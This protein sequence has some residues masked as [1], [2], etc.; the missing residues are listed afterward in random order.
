MRDYGA[1][2]AGSA[3]RAAFEDSNVL[4]YAAEVRLAAPHDE[5]LSTEGLGAAGDGLLETTGGYGQSQLRCYGPAGGLVA[6]PVS[7]PADVYAEGACCVDGS[8]W[9]LTWRDGVALRWDLATLTL[10]GRL[11]YDR[12]GWGLCHDG[13]AVYCTDGSSEVVIRDPA[14]LAPAGSIRVR[15]AGGDEIDGLKAIA[16][17]GDQLWVGK[18]RSHWLMR[19]DRRTGLITGAVNLRDAFSQA[20]GRSDWGVT[21]IAAAAG[22]GEIALWA[23]GKHFPWLLRLG[24]APRGEAA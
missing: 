21:G 4:D 2:L 18:S 15:T 12:E 16:F 8:A 23:T 10:A 17:D 7:A 11:P 6:G 24:L 5:R 19:V 1:Q 13:G 22:R 9:Q 14:S 20:A 3:M